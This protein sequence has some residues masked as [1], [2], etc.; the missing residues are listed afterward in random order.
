MSASQTSAEQHPAPH[1]G[2]VNVILLFAGLAAGPFAWIVELVVSYAIASDL[3]TAMRRVGAPMG[4]RARFDEIALLLAINLICLAVAVAGGAIS[5]R[6]WLRTRA[7]KPGRAEAALDIGEGRTRFIAAFGVLSAAG[8][9]L[10]ILFNIVEPF[11]VPTC[12]SAAP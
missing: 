9:A 4:D 3:C 10:A 2:R 11:M 8:F 5:V 1:R 12:W 6:S 7:E